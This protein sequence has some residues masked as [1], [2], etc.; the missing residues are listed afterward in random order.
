V[1]DASPYVKRLSSHDDG[2]GPTEMGRPMPQIGAAFRQIA[3]Y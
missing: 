1:A 2:F 3:V